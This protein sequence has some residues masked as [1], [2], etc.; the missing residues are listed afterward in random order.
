MAVDQDHLRTRLADALADAGLTLEVNYAARDIMHGGLYV[1]R[2]YVRATLSVLEQLGMRYRSIEY[3]SNY[4]HIQIRQLCGDECAP[5]DR[6]HG[7]WR[8]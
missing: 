8:R 2:H 4:V 7:G 3:R 5:A 1:N 6:T